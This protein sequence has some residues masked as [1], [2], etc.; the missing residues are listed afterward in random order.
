MTP[1]YG[2]KITI[3][4]SPQPPPALSVPG[5][6]SYANRILIRA[7]LHPAP[8]TINN[9][10]PSRDT[11]NLVQC[12]QRIGLQI[13]QEPR[14]LRVLG[15]FPQCERPSSQPI[16]LATG[17]GG[18]TNRFLIPL[19]A[20]GQNTYHLLPTGNMAQRPMT[21]FIPW[22]SGFGVCRGGFKICG[23][24]PPAPAQVDCSQTTQIA[25]ALAL[26]GHQ[27]EPLNPRGPMAYWAMTCQVIEHGPHHPY[28]VPPDWSSAAFP[29]AL[30]VLGGGVRIANLHSPD[31][32]QAD[33][34]M[35]AILHQ[36]GLSYRFSPRGL[37]VEGR[38]Q[39]PLSFDCRQAPDLFAALIFLASYLPGE[40]VL[41]GLEN[42][43][44]KESDRLQEGVNLLQSFG[45]AHRR[46]D[47]F[48]AIV[49]GR[50]DQVPRDIT[51][52]PDHRMVMAAALFLRFN[53]GGSLGH[54]GE[55]GKSFPR[56]FK[57]MGFLP[58]ESLG[59][60]N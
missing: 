28:S 60:Q 45:I 39:A 21:G 34:L 32:L 26:A 22:L 4:P 6:K 3:A 9:I 16:S 1:P 55:V 42:L 24:H 23:P 33:S 56:F 11:Q 14:Q 15:C 18:T 7:S 41:T 49:G 29:L 2:G 43:R 51:T 59:W 53:G 58:G 36:V 30:G 48:L 10:S 54:P 5:S 20:L 38:P 46:G 27:V 12:L 31:P 47:D 8:L 37:V 50:P 35:L 44:H 13:V 19:L 52:A 17:D 57:L 25:S 40:S